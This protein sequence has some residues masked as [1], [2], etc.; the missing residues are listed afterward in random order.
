MNILESIKMAFASLMINKMRSFLTMLGI[1]IGISAVITIT[2]IGNSI[3][4]TLSNTFSTLGSASLE[5]YLEIK[6]DYEGDDY[7]QDE[8]DMIKLSMVDELISQ[9][10]NELYMSKTEDFGQAHLMNS[11][12]SELTV[13]MLGIT[14]SQFK[15]PTVR[16]QIIKGRAIT[17]TDCEE[18]KHSCL[19]TD[20]FLQQ[21]CKD[22]ENIIGKTLTFTME[23]GE[24]LHFTVVGVIEYTELER[25]QLGMNKSN[26]LNEIA[27]H[28]YVPYHTM[29]KLSG[30][31]PSKT[32]VD[33]VNICWTSECDVETAKKY[34]RE[35]FDKV[36]AN[37]DQW[38]VAIYDPEEQ[39]GMIN[40]V[41]NVITIAISIIAAISLIVGGVGVMNIMLVSILERTREI[42][43]RKAM[44][45]LNTDIRRQF[46]IEAIIICLIGGLIGVLIGITN[47]FLISAIAKA[48]MNSMASQYAEYITLTVQPSVT[49][50]IVSLGFSMAT[51]LVFGYYPAERAAKMNPIDAL[52]YE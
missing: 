14:D 31:D 19:V 8:D 37:N 23:S 49:A 29:L 41:L 30:K 2:T 1:I 33:W 16:K 34:C 52:R 35:Y 40:T 15:L 4:K 42:G 38:Q 17:K 20:I 39:L 12:N 26:N 43:V 11:E 25:N 36:Y 21:Y 5:L 48:L 13:N 45:A 32:S 27:T 50:I 28:I 44:G 47:G 10:P 6:D 9:H 18:K 3:Q 7:E 51:G 24:N 46:V 22:D